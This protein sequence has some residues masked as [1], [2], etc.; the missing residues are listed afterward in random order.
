MKNTFFK[1][2]VSLLFIIVN[3]TSYCQSSN[4][5]TY[6]SNKHF[7]TVGD[8]VPDIFFKVN[9]YKS[10]TV[11]LS[12]LHKKLILLDFW[13][14]YCGTCID[15]IPEVEKLQDQFKDDI[16]I[17]MVTKNPQSQV[18]ASR[19]TN[20]KKCKLPFI[21]GPNNLAGYF[22]Y[23]FVPQYAWI[24]GNGV[25]KYL[26]V[27]SDVNEKA[28]RNFLN[29]VIPQYTERKV[30]TLTNDQV[31]MIV[32]TYPTLGKN[33][34]ISSYLAPID[35]T[36]YE[37]YPGFRK[38]GLGPYNPIMESG[39][40]N[41]KDLYKTAYGFADLPASKGIS[42]DRIIVE[43][44]DTAGYADTNRFYLYDLYVKKPVPLPRVLKYMQSELDLYFNV[45]SRLEK[46]SV[47][48][49]ILKKLDNGHSCY[50][51]N[52]GAVYDD[53]DNRIL[54]V[55]L[56]W[57]TFL[58][59]ADGNRFDPPYTL[60]DETGIDPKQIVGFQMSINFNDMAEV[61]KSL[62]PYGL[63]IDEEKRSLNCIVI[64]NL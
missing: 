26:G 27:E 16:Q 38:N 13:G 33:F 52:P 3:H 2:S 18:D 12:Q 35:F 30:I 46:R 56:P 62:A 23:F 44:Q 19:A 60:I 9:N 5:P 57:S 47:T 29:G 7:L 55:N 20:V 59:A 28:I 51:T 24:D 21:N 42:F 34:F 53:I 48:C 63:T 8:K 1:F 6:L 40:F 39:S 54:K 14:T 22:K 61:K 32:D 64:S 31:P 45:S 43:F 10:P 17:I 36:K 15:A 37:L 25:I 58:N 49:L 50:S 11:K 4:D 41:F